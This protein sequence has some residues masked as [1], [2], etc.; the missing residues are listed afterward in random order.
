MPLRKSAVPVV[1]LLFLSAC[2]TNP[3]F[4]PSVDG[5]F[6]TGLALYEQGRYEDAIEQFNQALGIDPEHAQSYLYLGRSLFHLGRW[7]EAVS[8]L[9]GVY[10]RVSTD[11]QEEFVGELLDSMLNGALELL[12]KGNFVNAIAL[13]EEALRLEPESSRAKEDLGEVLM[14]FGTQLF[15][16]GRFNDAIDAYSESLDLAADK[17]QSYIGLARALFE[18]GDFS[19]ALKTLQKALQEWPESDELKSLF[20]QILQGN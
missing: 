9:R 12:Q 15:S 3:V 1:L 20:K 13:L 6:E 16:E 11:E 5:A 19:K 8:Y 2:V 18:N 4:G 10:L 17:I 14:M 7:L